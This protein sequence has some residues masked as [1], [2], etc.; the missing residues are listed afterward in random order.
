MKKCVLLSATLFVLILFMSACSPTEDPV[1]SDEPA[2]IPVL[3]TGQTASFT[4]IQT[5]DVHH[6]V[7]GTGPSATYGKE[8]DSTMGG[9]SRI[10]RK[11]AQIKAIQGAQGIPTVLVDS[12]DFF[13]GTVYDMSLGASPAALAFFENMGYDAITIGNHELDYGPG[14]LGG[15]FYLAIGDYPGVSKFN[16]PVVASNM[17]TD[18]APGTGDD[19]LEGLKAAGVIKDSLML[20][21]AN[22]VK[23]GILGFLGK[24]AESD[25]PLASPLTFIN[26]MTD[27]D[28]IAAIQAKVDALEADGAH[29]VIALSHSGITDPNG[30]PGGDDI[31]LADNVTG[32]DIIASGHDHEMTDDVVLEN[33][34]RIICAGRYGENLAQLDV[35]V[36]IGTGVDTAVLTNHTIDSNLVEYGSIK[37]FLVGALD[38]GINEALAANG[39]PEVNDIVAGT[40]SDNMGMPDMVEE[41]G[42]GNLAADSLRYTLGGAEGNPSLGIVANGL[43]RNGYAYGQEISFADLYNTLPL[44]MTLDPVNQTIP[45]YPLLMV[46]V[47]A[48]SIVSLCNLASLTIAANNDAFMTALLNSGVPAYIQKY[49]LLKNLKSDYYLNMSGI[50]YSYAADYSVAAGSIALYGPTDFSCQSAAPI[51]LAGIGASYIPCVFDLY[52]AKMFLDPTMQGLLTAAGLSINPMVMG[53]GGLEA[54]SEAN[55]MSARLDR[56][57]ETDGV[58]EVKEWMALLQYVTNPTASA[59]LNSLIL[60]AYYGTTALESGNASRVNEPAP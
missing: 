57:A 17:V 19:Y 8:T 12:G 18:S 42:I 4:L 13:M 41:T 27:G 23:V 37:V 10:A 60:D 1:I 9:Y 49:Y 54:L 29:V 36:T 15:F 31:D 32:I 44:G 40:N 34:T 28:E 20:T 7:V 33:G 59:G 16:V 50:R 35:T 24:K 38:S 6:H 47:D 3:E 55:I 39:L 22:G 51:P 58:Q 25:A 48:T 52:M 46:Y 45:G 26:D 30:T 21:L 56:D 11:I 14:P 43:I 5:T 53:G 2:V